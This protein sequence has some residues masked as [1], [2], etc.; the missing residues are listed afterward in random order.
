MVGKQEPHI[1]L[2]ISFTPND[3]L[4]VR[5]SPQRQKRIT[6]LPMPPVI[7]DADQEYENSPE[8]EVD[9]D[10]KDGQKVKKPRYVG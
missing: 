9:L 8:H 3:I 2:Y 1:Y 4:I 7:D 5:P 6:E 10:K